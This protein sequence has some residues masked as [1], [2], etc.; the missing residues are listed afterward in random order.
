MKR[1]AVLVS[2]LGA[3][4][5]IA[6]GSAFVGRTDP[7]AKISKS[8]HVIQ[9][10]GPITCDIGERFS[11]RLT[12][13]QAQTAAYAEGRTRA[14]CTGAELQWKVRA[15]SLLRTHFAQG[16]AQACALG[17]TR[18]NGRPTDSHQWCVDVTLVPA[19]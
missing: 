6:S 3:L 13:T 9:A 18:R 15:I 12:I 4:V 19:S 14:R 5:L 2:M 10:T 8:G 1:V 17:I 7:T 11:L 16:T